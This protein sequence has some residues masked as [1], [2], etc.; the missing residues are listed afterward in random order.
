MEIKNRDI[1]EAMHG[2]NI[3][4]CSVRSADCISFLMLENIDEAAHG[5]K[6]IVNLFL[7]SPLE[8]GFPGIHIVDL[9]DQ[10]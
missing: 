1:A 7:K 6:R 5:Q 4:D 2:F 8:R 3:Y 9:T 10:K